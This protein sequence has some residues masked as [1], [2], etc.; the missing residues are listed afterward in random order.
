MVDVKV[1]STVKLNEAFKEKDEKYRVWATQDPRKESLKGGDGPP[2]H[3]PRRGRPQR[4]CQEREKLRP[5][6][7][8]DWVRMAQSLIRY[9]VVIVGK[10]F[11]KGSWVSEAW[12][13]AHPEEFE[14]EH[15][16]APE[17]IPT[18]EERRE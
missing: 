3:L 14:E 16:G 17:R 18:V 9:N 7:H 8:V 11:D 10:F 1:T 15:Q 13:K 6:I 12:R 5:D 2:H 4:H